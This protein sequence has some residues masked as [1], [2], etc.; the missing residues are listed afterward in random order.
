ML[1]S[2]FSTKTPKLTIEKDDK[3]EWRW[4]IKIGSDIIGCSSEG[5]HNRIECLENILNVEQRIKYLR[6]NGLI[7]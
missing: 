5:Y 2:R 6:E 4:N 7:K 1:T 3:E